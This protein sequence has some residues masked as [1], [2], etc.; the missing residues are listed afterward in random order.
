M[1]IF[2]NIYNKLLNYP[3]EILFCDIDQQVTA[4]SFKNKIF[5]IGVPTY[6]VIPVNP[7]DKLTGLAFNDLMI[8]TNKCEKSFCIESGTALIFNNDRLLHAIDEI[9][10]DRLALRIYIKYSL[11]GLVRA[12]D[13]NNKVFDLGKSIQ[14]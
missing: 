9:K 1:E 6:H 14:L 4:E 13:S 12:T 8:S 10:T 2:T 5:E 7:T 3:N 11:D